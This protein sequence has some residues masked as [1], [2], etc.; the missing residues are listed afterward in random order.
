MEKPTKKQV[1]KWC[2]ALRS[3]KYKQGVERLQTDKGYC[4]LGVAVDVFVPKGKQELY[5][6]GT[7]KGCIP[8]R[9]SA[10]PEWLHDMP[11]MSRDRWDEF[12]ISLEKL[13]DNKGYT[14]DEIADV[15]EIEFIHGI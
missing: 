6:N 4:C 2:D 3:G 7:L 9:Q 8:R 14:F 15:L 13:N 12:D 5:P 10:A 1:K 11:V